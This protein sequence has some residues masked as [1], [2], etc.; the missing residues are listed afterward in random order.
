MKPRLVKSQRELEG[1]F[2]D[3]W[4]LVDDDDEVETWADDA[5]LAVVGSP[6]PRQDGA[7]RASG[8]AR[9]TVDVQL[10]GMLHAAVLRAPS[11]RCRVTALDVEAARA[12]PG[13]RAVIGPDD[14]V[15]M[16]GDA[17]LTAEP[18]WAGAPVAVLA[19]DT[20]E[21]AAAG[22]AALAPA[23]EPLPRFGSRPGSPSSASRRIHARPSG[24]TPMPRSRRPM[25]GSS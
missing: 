5:E 16:T 21:A 12:T 1:R 3:V 11:A 8:A 10:A 13:V 25:H 18:S 23:V 6:A 4:V 14:P 9:Y 20:P 7:V 24:A 22:L 15:T 2:E 19:A 17:I